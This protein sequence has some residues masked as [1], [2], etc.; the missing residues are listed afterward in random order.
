MKLYTPKSNTESNPVPFQAMQYG[1]DK[2]A[3]EHVKHCYMGY[4]NEILKIP[5]DMMGT[6]KNAFYAVKTVN[7]WQRI[8]KGDFVVIKDGEPMLIPYAVFQLSFDEA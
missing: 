7:G 2:E 6:P 4:N 1:T 3:D 5:G 8:E